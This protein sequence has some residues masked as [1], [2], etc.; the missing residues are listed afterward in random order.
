LREVGRQHLH[1]DLPSETQLLGD[2]DAGHAA[3]AEL[4]FE[5]V[6]AAESLL[7]LLADA[8]RHIPP[9]QRGEAEETSLETTR[10]PRPGPAAWLT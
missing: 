5:D 8:R 10:W 6:C 4:A 7:K 9:V 2:E 1:R 3:A